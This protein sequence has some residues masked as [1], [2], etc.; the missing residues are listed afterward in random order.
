MTK[1]ADRI[2]AAL[3]E[4][5]ACRAMLD[6]PHPAIDARIGTLR[7]ALEDALA[8]AA[9][10]RHAMFTPERVARLAALWP[11]PTPLDDIRADL[12]ALPGPTIPDNRKLIDHA[13]YRGLKGR[14]RFLGKETIQ[15][16]GSAIS[17]AKTTFTPE[18]DAALAEGWNRGDSP[19]AILAAINALPGGR[20]TEGPL[21]NRRRRLGLPDRDLRGRNGP[22]AQTKFSPE[23]D[24]ALREGWLRGDSPAVIL[25]AINALPGK[26]VTESPLFN[27]R[28]RLGLPDRGLR[29]QK[30]AAAIAL[31]RAG[32]QQQEVAT[33]PAWA[34]YFT[35]ARD[36][37]LRDGWL[38][39]DSPAHILAAINA[40]PGQTIRHL[41]T[42]FH[43]RK[44]LGLPERAM[45]GRKAAQPAPSPAPA[46]ELPP[47]LP[48]PAPESMQDIRARQEDMARD[49]LRDAQPEA[50]VQQQT[51]LSMARIAELSADLAARADA[52]QDRRLAKARDMLRKN[53]QPT[54]VTAHTRL[55][56]REVYRLQAEIR[57]EG[58]AA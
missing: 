44:R 41:G 26:P 7:A 54:V 34:G 8:G 32:D 58:R 17:A 56:L 2:A 16:L 14:R 36:A 33:A 52:A 20:I 1:A 31:R 10:K 15:R 50:L 55:P 53:S 51:G 12:N 24:S 22:A 28:K 57:R 38:R 21:F 42:M 23:R 35:A 39:G 48:A 3:A 5:E 47:P 49:M 4:A 46:I 45:P 43:R 19:A 40:L 6:T 13:K 30:G 18:R 27:R 11:T 9:A 29:G 37:A 25:A